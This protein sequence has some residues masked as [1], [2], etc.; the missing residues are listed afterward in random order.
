MARPQSFI[1]RRPSVLRLGR[2]HTRA[3]LA[4]RSDY[5]RA[6]CKILQ[7]FY[8]PL[9]ICLLRQHEIETLN[10]EDFKRNANWLQMLTSLIEDIQDHET[11][12]ADEALGKWAKERDEIRCGGR[13]PSDV[14]Q[15]S[16]SNSFLSPKRRMKMKNIFNAQFGSVFRTYHN[17]TYFS[18]RLFR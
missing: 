6:I 17:P 1:F 9:V 11:A 8:R 10:N 5:K 4:Y 18:R 7:E 15:N 2:R 12:E 3:W 16:L 14:M 13:K